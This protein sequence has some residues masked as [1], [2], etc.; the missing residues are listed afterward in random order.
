LVVRSGTSSGY[1]FDVVFDTAHGMVAGQVV[2]VAGAPVGTIVA[3]HLTHDFKARM[4]L[5]IDSRFAPLR[6]DATCRILP[7]GLISEDYVECDPGRAAAAL[8]KGA[9]GLPTVPVTRTAA[10]VSL[11]DLL[12]IFTLP[13]GDRL[14]LM[15]NELGIATA[16]QGDNINAVLRRANPALAQARR[17]LSIVDAQRRQ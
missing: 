10:P 2:K 12:N 15:L 5:Q 9:G 7:E 4:E 17:V 11:Q 6:D 1:R 3:V 13:T 14:R 16:G 8:E